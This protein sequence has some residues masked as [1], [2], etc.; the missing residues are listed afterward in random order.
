[1]SDLVALAHDGDV[2][3]VV[4]S[5]PDKR[6]ALSADLVERLLDAI[7]QVRERGS[8][9]MILR[10]EGKNF[11]AGFDFGDLDTQSEADLLLRFVRIETLLQRLASSACLTVAMAH[12]RNFGA[13][14]DIIAACR[15]RLA[16]A[17]A[18]FRMPGLKFG[19]VLG[20]RRFASLVGRERA[21][22]ILE[23]TATFDAQEA[24]EIGFV[25]QVLPDSGPGQYKSVVREQ[26]DLLPEESRRRLYEAL[27]YET[28]DADLASLVRSCSGRDFKARIRQYL[29]NSAQS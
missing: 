6:N 27:P 15:L 4:L 1:M 19:V 7:D 29:D 22:R 9:A 10:G 17:D 24:L 2:S 28:A 20:T 25:D 13:G 16:A 21:R 12:G 5:R 18:T 14:V 23:R 8:R 26:T 3:E 11:C